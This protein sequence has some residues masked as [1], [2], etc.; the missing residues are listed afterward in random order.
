MFGKVLWESWRSFCLTFH[1]FG[2]YTAKHKK[3]RVY[4]KLLHVTFISISIKICE[5][6]H[7]SVWIYMELLKGENNPKIWYGASQ[8]IWMQKC[9]NIWEKMN[10]FDVSFCHEGKI[11]WGAVDPN[12]KKYSQ[13]D[14]TTSYKYFCRNVE[15]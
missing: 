8:W 1:L 15:D 9:R 11:H 5:D 3:A 10:M 13:N 6:M 12:K 14:K 2:F 7:L 4:H